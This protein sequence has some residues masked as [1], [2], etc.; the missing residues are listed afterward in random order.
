MQTLRRGRIQLFA[1]L[2]ILVAGLHLAT[3]AWSDSTDVTPIARLASEEISS[4]ELSAYPLP[5][6]DPLAGA[7]ACMGRLPDGALVCVNRKSV[8]HVGID[9]IYIEEADR[10]A[11]IKVLNFTPPNCPPEIFER[12]NLVTLSGVMGTVGRERVIYASDNF[13]CDYSC[14]TKV[15]PI[16]MSS[17]AI[18]GWPVNPKDPQGRR[19]QGLPPIGILVKIWGRVTAIGADQDDGFYIY[20]NDGWNKKDGSDANVAG[21]RVYCNP[22]PMIGD[23]VAAVG[24]LGKKIY[25]PTPQGPA[26][27]EVTVPIVR[28]NLDADPYLPTGGGVTQTTTG[29]VSGTVRLVG[30]TAP[31][32]DVRVTTEHDS[33]LL[34]NVTSEGTPFTVRSIPPMDYTSDPPTGG[35]LISATAAGFI[36]DTK[37]AAAGATG[38]SLDLQPS[39]ERVEVKTSRASIAVCNDN[40]RA[41]ITAMM[42][43]CE[44]KGLTNRGIRLV[45]TK[46]TLIGGT[47][48]PGDPTNTRKA[49]LTTDNYGFAEVQLVASPD[50]VGIAVITAS[51]VSDPTQT[52]QVSVT[53]RGAEV[54]L[55]A[56]PKYLTGPGTSAVTVQVLDNGT[57]IAGARVTFRT[58][59]GGFQEAAGVGQTYE[60]VT[61]SLGVA[62]AT[63]VMSSPGTATVRAIYS[64]SCNQQTVSWAP[65]SYKST[66][67]HGYGVQYSNPLIVD[68]DQASDGKRE[69]VIVDTDGTLKALTPGATE[70]SP[71][72][73]L[74]Q[75]VMHL[76]GNNSPSCVV[77]DQDRS[78]RPCV[79]IPSESQQNVCAYAWNGTAL[80]GWPAGA[81]Y[82]FIR[83]AAAI[84]DVNLDGSPE[85]VAGDESCYVFSWNPTGDWRKSGT[86]D[87][88]FL[89]RNLTGTTSTTIYNTTC[90]LGDIGSEAGSPFLGGPD[91]IPD[92]VVGSNHTTA[93]FAFPGDVWGDFVPSPRYLDGYPR[94]SG[95]RAGTSPAIGDID[96]DSLNDMVIGSDDGKL[97]MWLS[98][99]KAWSSQATGGAVKS[100]PLLYDLDGDGKLDAVAGS[101]SGRL[102]A[103]N[104]LGQ[105]PDGWAGGIKL[106]TS[107]TYPIESSPVL[108][109]VTNDGVPDIVVGCN[110][111]NIYAVYTQGVS[112]RDG[113]G[114]MTGP[115]A[116]TRCCIPPAD[117][118]ALV[119]TAPVIDD[120]D[121]DG[122]VEVLAGS[123]RGIYVFHFDSAYDA[124]NSAKFP[125]PTFHRDNARTGCVTPWP[126]PIRGSIQGIVT[127][128]VGGQQQPVSSAKVYIKYGDGSSVPDPNGVNRD[129]VLT[130]GSSDISQVGCGSYCIN[131]LEADKTYQLV[132]EIT[133]Y[134]QKTIGD[135]QIPAVGETHPRMYRIDVQFP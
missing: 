76:P 103:F 114:Q 74:W 10:S 58:D 52:S 28:T 14:L 106:N 125:W 45:T 102:W 124:P 126:A 61:N 30:Q 93:V 31:G 134:P 54:V 2:L 79:F 68:L 111:G 65:V 135:I 123:D 22:G 51:S 67:W 117:T 94:S 43:D 72:S 40:D 119:L 78:G 17:P 12:G 46:G 32:R 108:G 26:G 69:A 48:D 33:V 39:S 19:V 90:A 101:D 116:W 4:D 16:G 84:A 131:Q 35:G 55:S 15:N 120:I 107:G 77:L 5:I 83:C 133:G 96:G 98:S 37:A 129:Y 63:L 122:K 1:A 11:G 38:I 60:T 62:S 121:N 81:D 97:Y 104:W 7:I 132:V 70:S 13:G 56:Q 71:A 109:D 47:P 89:W 41:L 20:A 118:T 49:L 99:T 127:K 36:S 86:W 18:L 66:P 9:N 113:L 8:T 3:C 29:T 85:I 110:D 73:V 64:N 59:L 80:A 105:A 82:R 6:A 112:H 128:L 25:D 53:L 57:P 95:G 75:K 34:H 27:D 21:V 23:F 91:G 44:G 50:P 87:S 130:T 88:S 42:R 115:I 92:V 24:V 100:S